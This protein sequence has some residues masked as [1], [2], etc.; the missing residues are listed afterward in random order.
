MANQSRK[1]SRNK[2]R[3]AIKQGSDIYRQALSQAEKVESDLKKT[4]SKLSWYWRLGIAV[5][6]LLRCWK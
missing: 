5:K 3:E 6:I 4:I 1:V 2:E